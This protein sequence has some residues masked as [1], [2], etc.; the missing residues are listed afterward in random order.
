MFLSLLTSMA[1][2]TVVWQMDTIPVSV[3]SSSVKQQLEYS[4]LSNPVT[5][6]TLKR[7]EGLIDAPKGLSGVVPGLFMPDYGSSMTSSI[8][9]RGIGS[10]MENPVMGLYVDDVPVLDKNNFDFAFLDIRRVDMMRGPH[11][12]LYGRNAMLGVM[13]IETLSPKIWQ[14]IRARAEY[15]SANSINVNASVYKGHIGAAVMYKHCGGYYENEYT[16]H[17]CDVSDM[18]AVRLRYTGRKYGIDMDNSLSVSYTDQGGYPYRLWKNGNLASVSYND[19]ST[20][21]RLS[22]VDGFRMNF[23]SRGMNL[24]SVTS[25]QLLFDSMDLDQD[26]TSQSMFTLNQSQRQGAVTQEVILR[27]E[28]HPS[29]WNSQTGVFASV[30]FNRMSAPV[31]FLQDGIRTL[32]LDNA[33]EHIPDELGK[34]SIYEKNFLISSDFDLWNYNLAAYHESYF[35]LGRWFLTAGLRVDHEGNFMNYDSHS[36]IHFKLTSMPDYLPFSTIYDGDESEFFFQVSPK[37]SAVYDVSSV[38]MR[39]RG[40]FLKFSASISRGYKSGGFN[41]QIF[42]DILQNKMMNGMMRKLGFYLDS[43]NNVS[44]S[45]TKYKPESCTDYEV[46]GRLGI[47][48]SEHVFD[49]SA[50]VFYISCRNQQITV[51]PYGNGTGRMMTNAGKSRSMGV[52]SEASWRW[53]GLSVNVSAGF[54]DARFTDYD[55]GRED[56]SGNRVPYSPSCTAYSRVGYCFSLDSRVIRSVS[57]A[58]DAMYTGRITWNELGDVSQPGYWSFGC[59]AR[60]SLPKFDI[61]FRGENISDAEYAVFYFKSVGNSF[62]QI[63]KPRRFTVGLSFDL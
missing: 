10:R 62:F 41:T 14:G 15:G 17:K 13:S 56:Y 58:A 25:I 9:I 2:G 60:L 31:R 57:V 51:F 29:W 32:I 11:G 27:P 55:D 46:G 50:N 33:N 23:H 21:K 34:L 59:D 47:K 44:A 42:S 61:Y 12:T 49:L 45:S 22:L 63:G 28:S 48:R 37:I 16:G 30:K 7:I 36:D 54:T 53:K 18:A 8:Y 1:L 24:S 4:E 52:E 39:K 3:V 40:E 35:R 26:F 20:Y 43:E 5:T 38:S 6:L 19:K